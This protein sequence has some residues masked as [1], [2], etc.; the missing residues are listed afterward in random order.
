MKTIFTVLLFAFITTFGY[1]QPVKEKISSIENEIRLA[2]EKKKEL[3]NQLETLK[4]EKISKDLEAVGLP[5]IFP[6]EQLIKHSAFYLTYSEKHE[7]PRWVA[8]I[9]LP[10]VITGTVTRTNDFRPDPFVTT[11][12]AVEADYY[13][14][15]LNA[16]STWEYDGFGYD[17]G[18]LA[19]S[20]DFRWSQKALSESYYYS[21]ITPQVPEF[22]REGWGD[23][24]DAIRG[25]IFRNPST[26][27]QVIT[28]PVLHDSLKRIER[29]IHKVSIPE[30]FWKIA[31]DEK[32]KK[33]I[34]FMM[35]NQDIAKPLKT[36]AVPISKIEKVTGLRFF[37]KLKPEELADIRNQKNISDW[38]PEENLG[39]VDPLDQELLP[40]NVFNTDVA[41]NYIDDRGEISVVG[42]V[43]GARISKA[44][45]ILLN[46][47]KQFPNQVFTV[48]IRK[49]FIPNF[50]YNPETELLGKMIIV[51]G[52]I[53]GL[54]GVPAMFIENENHLGFFDIEQNQ[55]EKD[56]TRQRIKK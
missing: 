6:G 51:K 27:I 21:N 22:N 56:K 50:S 28:G 38:L 24:E 48:F 32:N 37:S 14:K 36:Y 47:D 19:P 10:D 15:E 16:D 52:R 46:L 54:S 8:H 29:G 34:G 11:G 5:T 3:I 20:A 40:K 25:Y 49:Q 26:Q 9:I 17:R 33:A 35:P 4:L 18:H 12:S 41:K 1:S 44:G 43:V 53:V 42:T 2:D 13:L 31:F 55:A 23:L 39:D 45:N 7:V 30:Y